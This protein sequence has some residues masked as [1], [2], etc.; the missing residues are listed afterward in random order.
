MDECSASSACEV[1]VGVCSIYS[2]CEVLCVYYI[3]S[4][5]F[6]LLERKVWLSVVYAGGV[7]W[8]CLCL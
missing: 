5:V 3:L 6:L 1:K 4:I 2:A 7:V 8:Q